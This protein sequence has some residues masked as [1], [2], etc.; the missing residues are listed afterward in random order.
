[1][2][3]IMP[4]PILEQMKR[5]AAETGV[6]LVDLIREFLEQEGRGRPTGP[7]GPRGRRDK[8]NRRA[9]R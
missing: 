7:S 5:T 1:M 2:E 4:R 6:S 8:N 3:R 9:R